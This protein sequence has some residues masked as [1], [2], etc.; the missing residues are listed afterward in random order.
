[1]T[2]SIARACRRRFGEQAR[3]DGV[4]RVS[5]GASSQTWRFELQRP[6]AP[7]GAGAMAIEA[8]QVVLQLFAGGRQYP[9]ALDK[10]TQARVQRAAFAAGVPTPEVLFV[11][12]AEDG[13]GE[14][15]ATAWCE[16]ETLGQRI[17]HGERFAAA[18]ARLVRDCAD[19]LA[20]IHRVNIATLPPL[21]E[22]QA[23]D[24]VQLLAETH[25]AYG[26]SVPVFELALQWL[27]D[28]LPP[29]VTPCLVHGDF[30][31]GNLMVD[32]EGLRCVLDWEMAHLGDPLEDLGW[33]SVNAWRFGRIDRPIGGFG[34]R[35]AFY[36]ACSA[37]SRRA[38]DPASVR[39]W[40]VF[41]TLQW[42]VMCQWFG[43]QF[44]DG[45]V[46]D[47]ERVA[48]GR[49]ISEVQLDLMDLFRG[50]D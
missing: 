5:A 37:A 41:G 18:R 7:Q 25:R 48:I 17:V 10:G 35:Q 15:F 16:G 11:L 45:G 31:T 20:A 9:G 12:E 30:R 26:A 23:R 13:I 3:I 21:A 34:E 40:Q 46:R 36:D 39:F 33:L 42:G 43:A 44:L 28:H 8:V 19:V 29:P 2:E 22:R 49:R 1:M 47:I 27:E 24:G 32:E 38:T 6:P 50:R 4:T 14:G